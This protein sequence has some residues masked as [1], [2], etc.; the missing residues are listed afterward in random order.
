MSI[1]DTCR[2][3]KSAAIKLAACSTEIK[4][5]AL[6]RIAKELAAHKEEIFRANQEDLRRSEAE[7]LPVPLLKRLRFDESK[8]TDVIAGINS[9]IELEDPVGRTLLATE[10]DDGLE[11]YRVT[12]PIGAIGVIF[13][14]RPDAL[15]QISTLCLKSGNGVLLKG[16]SEAVE[17]NRVLARI[18][19]SASEAAGIPEGWCSLLETRYEISELLK[20]DK[21]IDLIIPRGS[22]EFVRYIM[23]NTNIP[24]M[25][26]ADGICH[27]YIDSAA[28]PRMALRIAIDSKTQYVAVCN[29]METLL[30]HRDIAKTFLPMLKKAA[31]EKHVELYGCSETAAIIDVS[32]ATEDDWRT[33][34]LDYKLSVRVVG[35]LDEAIDHINTY[36]SGHTDAIV[37]GDRENAAKFMSLVD[38]GNVFWN[39]STRFSDGFRYGLGAEV[40]ISTGKLHARGPVGLDGLVIYK[41]M[42]LGNGQIVSD[43]AEKRRSFTHRKL[44]RN[45]PL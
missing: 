25:G 11:L 18:I 43:Y 8:L 36:G 37:T 35:S 30:V 7:N 3:V 33:E 15:V 2:S 28:D 40:G 24:V 4:N 27:C 19:I 1:A 21:Y 34:Y 41:Y 20:Q 29:A 5:G 17:T 26:H 44:D 13:E 9:L 10:L 23:D 12:C 22:N 14:S 38:S 42:L 45:F 32:P 31:D 16:G 6:A 39:C